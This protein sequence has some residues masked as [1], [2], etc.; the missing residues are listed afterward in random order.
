MQLRHVKQHQ[1][2]QHTTVSDESMNLWARELLKCWQPCLGLVRTRPNC[3]TIG[4]N[5]TWKKI[6]L[7]SNYRLIQIFEYH[8]QSCRY[9]FYMELHTK[10]TTCYKTQY[11]F[12]SLCGISL[13]QWTTMLALWCFLSR[14]W[15]SCDFCLSSINKC[16]AS[17]QQISQAPRVT[18]VHCRH[19]CW[20]SMDWVNNSSACSHRLKY[21]CTQLHHCSTRLTIPVH[22][23]YFHHWITW[24]Q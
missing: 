20:L 21:N 17:I 22:P 4:F 3:C 1:Y 10:V 12:S 14:P 6:L 16:T 19:S 13:F 7:R 15:T 2:L 18:D 23:S 11:V 9:I 8:M 5:H 24:L